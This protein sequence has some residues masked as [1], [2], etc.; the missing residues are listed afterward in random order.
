MPVDFVYSG[1]IPLQVKKTWMN[2]LGNGILSIVGA[3]LYN[4]IANSYK[5]NVTPTMM[6]ANLGHFASSLVSNKKNSL[7]YALIIFSFI[8][9]LLGGYGLI[10]L[11][12]NFYKFQKS[13]LDSLLNNLILLAPIIA[14][15]ISYFLYSDEEFNDA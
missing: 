4:S 5:V 10:Y 12:F 2:L 3:F 11:I 14:L 1:N 13:Y 7:F 8:A 6:T 15:F 9:G